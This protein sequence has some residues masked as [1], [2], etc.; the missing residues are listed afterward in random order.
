MND[1]TTT[2][3][4]KF[5]IGWLFLVAAVGLFLGHFWN[6]GPVVH[7]IIGLFVVSK[8][9]MSMTGMHLLL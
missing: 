2:G 6:Y 9:F 4:K 3:K 7:G 8:F 5:S 1:K